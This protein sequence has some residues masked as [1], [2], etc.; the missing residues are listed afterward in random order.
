MGNQAFM[1]NDARKRSSQN[2][3]LA[4]LGDLELNVQNLEDDRYI[5]TA[6]ESLADMGKTVEGLQSVHT[7]AMTAQELLKMKREDV[8][9]QC[10]AGIDTILQDPLMVYYDF[11]KTIPG[12]DPK[13]KSVEV[14]KTD[15]S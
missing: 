2:Q 3:D 9:N 8:I 15:G 1:E 12:E 5:H 6:V 4:P 14:K 13:I 11:T 7:D 10:Y